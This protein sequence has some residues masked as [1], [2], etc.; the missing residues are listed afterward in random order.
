[1]NGVRVNGPKTFMN[2][3]MRVDAPGCILVGNNI[4]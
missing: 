1:M 4:S 2:F 3:N